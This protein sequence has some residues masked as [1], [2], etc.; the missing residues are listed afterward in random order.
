MDGWNNAAGG[1]GVCDKSSLLEQ[2]DRSTQ[3]GVRRLYRG[4]K[5]RSAADGFAAK[6]QKSDTK[7][8][9]NSGGEPLRVIVVWRLKRRGGGG[10][11]GVGLPARLRVAQ[12]VG[13]SPVRW[14]S[15]PPLSLKLTLASKSAKAP[16]QP[17]GS[18][19]ETPQRRTGENRLL[20]GYADKAPLEQASQAARTAALLTA[21]RPSCHEFLRRETVQK[22]FS[23]FSPLLVLFW[24]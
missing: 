10:A 22:V 24:Q 8:G 18:P 3:A 9:E 20:R 17:A 2:V 11:S 21:S 12:V 6:P 13:E 1:G 4:A 19:S 23:F 14:A 16:P 5:F 7:R 15:T